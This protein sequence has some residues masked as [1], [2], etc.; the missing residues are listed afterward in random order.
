MAAPQNFRSAFNGFNREDV[1][2][3]LEYINGKHTSQVNQLTSE[4]EYLRSRLE[5]MPDVSALEQERDELRAQLEELQARYDE[6]E[7]KQA[8]QPV[9]QE[10]YSVNRELETYRRAER[11][12][13]MARERAELV[14]HQ[15]NSVL[16][17][18]LSRVDALSAEVCP[19]AEQAMEQLEQLRTLVD[20]GRQALQ[21]AVSVMSALRPNNE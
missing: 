5:E 8:Q 6:L 2:R 16:A 11:T 19:K 3:Y 1:V 9:Q 21:E 20:A 15:T 12:E 7:Q 14:Y 18:T 17:E 4:A 13:R 10:E